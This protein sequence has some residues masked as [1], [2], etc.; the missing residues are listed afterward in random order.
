MKLPS[1]L[2]NTPCF[3]SRSSLSCGQVTVI[4]QYFPSSQMMVEAVCRGHV[5]LMHPSPQYSLMHNA[6]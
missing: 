6:E 2:P 3:T 1:L 4:C 5:L